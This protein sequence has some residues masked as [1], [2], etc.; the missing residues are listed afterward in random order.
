MLIF[1][2]TVHTS[3]LLTKTRTSNRKSRCKICDISEVISLLIIYSL[4][5]SKDILGSL[6]FAINFRYLIQ[7]ISG[8]GK[9]KEWG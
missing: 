7:S 3:C 1:L 9:N 5:I 2:Y 8:Q 6:S 4:H